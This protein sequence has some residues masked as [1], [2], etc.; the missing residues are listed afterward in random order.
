MKYY[1][2]AS[3]GFKAPHING[4]PEDG[5][6]YALCDICGRKMRVNEM[7]YTY[8]TRGTLLVCPNDYEDPHPQDYIKSFKEKPQPRLGRPEG[9]DTFHYIHT[10]SEIEGGDTSNPTGRSPDTPDELK[11]TATGSTTILLTWSFYGNPGS[12]PITGFKV[13]R[14]SPVGGGFSTV[15]ADTESVALRYT[16]TGLTTATQYNYRVS[17][18]NRLG[19]GSASNEANDTTD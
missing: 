18:I 11:A 4:Y 9:P 5:Y 17:A 3:Y 10:A 12:G 7:K 14:E 6:Y 2:S 13:E 15:K 19:T 16:D 1:K 8:G